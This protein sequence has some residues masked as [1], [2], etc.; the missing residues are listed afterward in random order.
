MIEDYYDQTVSVIT[1]ST[2]AWGSTGTR[3]T[4][5]TFLAA[6]NPYGSE[7]FAADKKT[8]F[9]EYKMYCP[10]S[11][12]ITERQIVRWN[13]ND[14]GVVFVKNTFAMDHHKT[15]ALKRQS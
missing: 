7:R 15:V 5:A 10:S 3:T 13:S 2:G 14:Y 11:I 1:M 9:A 12:S 8:V 4:A 6:V